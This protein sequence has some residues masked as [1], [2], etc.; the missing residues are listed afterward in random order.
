MST[1][2]QPV[3]L[4][5][6]PQ[7]AAPLAADAECDVCIVGAGI[8][9]LLIAEQLSSQGRR[10]IV[11]DSGLVARGETSR[12]TAHVVN[13]LDDRYTELERLHGKDGAR[14]AAE[15]H[16]AAIR[17]IE[18]VVTKRGIECGWKRLDG[19]LVVNERH[20]A[21][22]E[23]LLEE[24]NAAARRAGVE[25]QRVAAL[26][27]LW[28]GGMWQGGVL[29]FPEQAQ[30][31]PLRLLS[32]IAEQIAREGVR[33]HSHT[34]VKDIKG[35]AEAIVQTSGGAVVRCQHVVVATNTPM[36]TTLAM[37]TKQS[38][39]QTYV[40]ALAVERGVLPPILL[41]DGPWEDDEFY[42]YIRLVPAEERGSN[43]GSSPQ[44]LLLLGGEDH[45]T[46]QGPDGDGPFV[47]LEAWA[48]KHLPMCREVVNRWSG[49]VMEPADGLGY[50][51]HSPVGPRNVYMVT[52]D[53]GNGMTHS[54]IGAMLIP[55]LIAGRTNPWADLY[56]PARKIGMHA[57]GAYAGENLNAV[58]QYRDWLR[59]GDVRSEAEIAPGTGA[60]VASGVNHLAVYKNESGQCTRLS[61]VCPH[62]GGLVRWNSVE[63]TWDCPCH[64]SRF[65]RTGK[66]LHGPA[67]EDLRS[68]D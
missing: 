37:H 25:T 3:W 51:G 57:L 10:V 40:L 11:L 15:S 19:Y 64:A 46:G 39:Y 20:S 44:D 7:G 38:G 50:I 67:N 61:A 55:D 30:M 2:H 56:D 65:E 27:A 62:L 22:R 33:I 28:P 12:T 6:S 1:L 16:S 23:E 17:H 53:S 58:A 45:K 34:H 14:L 59:R 42:N 47:R 5:A 36:N 48:R 13:A 31:H 66:L 35:G 43:A 24:E 32:G 21:K 29:R 4:D 9:G 63:K 18:A 26:P 68:A 54:A 8:A 49:E 52:G 41:W 60:I